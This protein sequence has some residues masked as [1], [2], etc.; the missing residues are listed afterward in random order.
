MHNIFPS[1]YE[2]TLE[3]RFRKTITNV[4]GE[5]CLVEIIDTSGLFNEF[6][7]FL[8]DEIRG[9][10]A[11]VCVYAV[12]DFTSYE[13]IEHYVKKIELIKPGAP[14]LMVCNKCD[15]PHN[16]RKVD[17][18]MSHTLSIKLGIPLLGAS[19]KDGSGVQ[20]VFSR[21]VRQLRL[22]KSVES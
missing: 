19:A 12:D 10:D 3:D 21:L 22:N 7:F 9:G 20:E 15:L 16:A 8:E 1:C 18:N 6:E 17:V 5:D 13:M 2:A 14:I 4:D 11:F